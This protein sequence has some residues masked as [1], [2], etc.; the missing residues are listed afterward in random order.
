MLANDFDGAASALCGTLCSSRTRRAP[1][2]VLSHATRMAA[3]YPPKKLEALRAN[4]GRGGSEA[5]EM[6]TLPAGTT[7]R[8]RQVTRRWFD[9]P[10]KGKR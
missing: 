5:R 6:G 3:I 2:G 10:W 7:P 4:K 8:A 1:I 9:S